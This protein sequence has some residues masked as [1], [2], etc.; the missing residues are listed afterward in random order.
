MT[1]HELRT[2]E[3]ILEPMTDRTDACGIAGE[4][5]YPMRSTMWTITAH[6]R[7]GGQRQFY[8]LAEVE[9]HV[10]T[11]ADRALYYAPEQEV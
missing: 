10:E 3:K 1:K 8:D 4:R 9:R 5:L 7:D 11:I 6:W 2:A